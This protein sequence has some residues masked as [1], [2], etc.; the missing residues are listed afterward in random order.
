[1]FFYI[2]FFKKNYKVICFGNNKFNST[3]EKLLKRYNLTK[4]FLYENGDN[5][6]L[7]EFYRDA[8]LFI[9]LSLMEGFGL[10]PLEA[11]YFNC[12]VVCSDIPIFREILADSCEYI[13]P[14]DPKNIKEKIEK[15]LKSQ[16]EQNKLIKLGQKKF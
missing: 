11:M 12:P 14:N 15:I 5:A 2:R 10:T 3:E 4:N 16:N 9:S 1:M 13:D 6:K 8:N 7:Q